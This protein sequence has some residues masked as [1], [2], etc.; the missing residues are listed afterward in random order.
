MF[1]LLHAQFGT[2]I[3]KEQNL[4]N[5]SIHANYDKSY[6]DREAYPKVK[7]NV[8]NKGHCALRCLQG[9]IRRNCLN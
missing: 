5:L 4:V 3:L 2:T 9:G 1:A 8:N 6:I 7:V